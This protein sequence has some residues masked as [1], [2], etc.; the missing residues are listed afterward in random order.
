MLAAQER[1]V[2]KLL[3]DAADAEFFDARVGYQRIASE[4]QALTARYGADNLIRRDEI[5][6]AAR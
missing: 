1:E 5:E 2:E 4:V 3:R 6:A